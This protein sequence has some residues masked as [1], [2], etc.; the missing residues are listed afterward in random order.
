MVTVRSRDNN[1]Q[2]TTP[3]IRHKQD[4][5]HGL[6]LLPGGPVSFMWVSGRFSQG[7]SSQRRAAGGQR[8]LLVHRFYAP[9]VTTYSQMLAMIATKLRLEGDDVSVF[10]TQPSYNG[11]YDGPPLPK[12]RIEDGVTVVRT[13]IPG[14]GTSIGRLLGGIVFGVRLMAHALWKRKRYDVIMVST[15]PPVVMGACGLAAARIAKAELVYHCMDL[16][17]EIAIAS[18]HAPAGP[19]ARLATL[20]DNHTINNAAK[21]VV[22]SQDMEQTIADRGISTERVHIQNN[23]TIDSSE[24]AQSAQLPPELAKSEKFRLLFAG[25]IG[26]FQGLDTLLDAISLDDSDDT[27]LVFLG[28]GAAKASLQEQTKKLQIS[29]RVRFVEH[30][31]LEVA[32]RA[33]EAADL[34]VVSLA[35]DLI[36]SAYP[37]KTVMYL[38][39]GCRVLAVVEDDSELAELV[40]SNQ[41]GMVANPGDVAGIA[42]AIATERSRE[43][44]PVDVER[45]RCIAASEFGAD[46][47]LAKW[48][49]LIA[50][51]RPQ[52]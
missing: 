31:P 21:T 41:L 45:A 10:T 15:V 16:Y 27:E 7:G 29:D 42:A 50:E 20:I 17:P 48:P 26:R 23:F 30:Q 35:P 46:S 6:H 38:E 13:S 3:T 39:M 28:G 9:D 2:F 34:A 37:S 22:L 4:W 12:K 1:G 11:I 51:V 25:N 19:I 43:P 18:R 47:V 5:S 49:D 14:G 24:S 8:V 33:M 32:L 44:M 36:G 52:T 40:T